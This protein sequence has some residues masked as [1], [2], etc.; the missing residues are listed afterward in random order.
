MASADRPD[1]AMPA[2]GWAAKS[3]DPVL[4]TGKDALPPE[5]KA[6]IQAHQK[7]K[8]YVLGPE[9][10]ISEAVAGELRKLG[11]VERISGPDP[12]TNAIAFARFS[13]GD[14][15]WGVVDPGHGFVFASHPPARSTPRPRAPLSASGKFGPLLLVTEAQALPA[16]R[17]R[18]TCSTSSPA[19][20]RTRCAGSTITAG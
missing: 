2:A 10:V 3:G 12:V 18:T 11:D 15:G 9:D 5:T 14:F 1:F 13:D 8:I 4:W 7:P 19:T 16:A 20:T 6:A 17:S